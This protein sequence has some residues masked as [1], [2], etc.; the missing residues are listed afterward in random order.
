LIS[1]PSSIDVMVSHY[2]RNYGLPEGSKT[3]VIAQVEKEFPLKARDYDITD[4]FKKF[5]GDVLVV[6]DVDDQEV[7]IEEARQMVEGHKHVSLI[8]T[9]GEGHR[10]IL[11][12]RSLIR[13]IK[14][15]L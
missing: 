15:F 8:E 14:S 7:F 11:A 2:C 1:S 13:I 4:A 6:H 3:A 5:S 12:S 9:G 10:K